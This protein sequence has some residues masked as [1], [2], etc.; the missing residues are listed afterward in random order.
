M[1]IQEVATRTVSDVA[2]ICRQRSTASRSGAW[3]FGFTTPPLYAGDLVKE[4]SETRG[5]LTLC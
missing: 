3:V 5:G 2:L 4:F 1:S